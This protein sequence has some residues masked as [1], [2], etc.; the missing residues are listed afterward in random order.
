M[1]YLKPFEHSLKLGWPF[2]D[3]SVIVD[4]YLIY[5]PSTRFQAQFFWYKIVGIKQ[6]Q[7]PC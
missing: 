7:E 6:Q 2:P 1:Q 5:S 4:M 3:Q